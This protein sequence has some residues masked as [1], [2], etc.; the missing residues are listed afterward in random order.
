MWVVAVQFSFRELGDFFHWLKT[1]IL[2]EYGGGQIFASLGEFLDQDRLNF[3]YKSRRNYVEIDSVTWD[4]ERI[5]KAG[6]VGGA[7]PRFACNWA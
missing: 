2:G 6:R 1:S 5:I 7:A 4:E 3:Y